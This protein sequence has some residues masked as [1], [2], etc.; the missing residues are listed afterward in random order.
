VT[1]ELTTKFLAWHSIPT[2]ASST[3]YKLAWNLCN[4]QVMFGQN[5]VDFERSTGITDASLKAAIS[6][7]GSRDEKSSISYFRLRGEVV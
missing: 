5:N 4:C 1:V 6:I 2:A 3:W 7:V